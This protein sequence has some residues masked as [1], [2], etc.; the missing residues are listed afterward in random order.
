LDEGHIVIVL[1][2]LLILELRLYDFED[3]NED[4]EDLRISGIPVPDLAH[5]LARDAARRPYH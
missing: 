4:E 2:L 3:G 5:S 1:V